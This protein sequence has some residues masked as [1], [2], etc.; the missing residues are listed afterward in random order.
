MALDHTS[1]LDDGTPKL[2]KEIVSLLRSKG[3]IVAETD[4]DSGS[5]RS[6][7]NGVKDFS[8]DLGRAPPDLN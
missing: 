5:Q 6:I 4:Q 7:D 3:Y 2:V 1:T 8:L